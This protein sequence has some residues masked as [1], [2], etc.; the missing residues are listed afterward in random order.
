MHG[1]ESI[2]ADVIIQIFDEDY[3]LEKELIKQVTDKKQ[4]N[5][6]SNYPTTMNAK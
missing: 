1:Y 4:S 2:P 6:I 3:D 5:S